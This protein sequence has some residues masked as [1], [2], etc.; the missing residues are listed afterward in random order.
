MDSMVVNLMSLLI[1][2][3]LYTFICGDALLLVI[4]SAPHGTVLHTTIP[5]IS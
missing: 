1:E 4:C 5:M 2:A 3:V